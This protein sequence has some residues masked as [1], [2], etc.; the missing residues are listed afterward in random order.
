MSVAEAPS[1]SIERACDVL[2]KAQRVLLTSHRRPD[3]D[4]TGSMAGR[5]VEARAWRVIAWA[6]PSTEVGSPTTSSPG[7]HS[8][9]SFSTCENCDTAGSGCAVPS[10]GSPTATP[11]LVGLY[12]TAA[13]WFTAST[14]RQPCGDPCAHALEQLCRDCPPLSS[15]IRR[16]IAAR[17]GGRIRRFSVALFW[18]PFRLIRESTLTCPACGRIGPIG[19]FEGRNGGGARTLPRGAA[20]R[21]NMSNEISRRK[22][23]GAAAT[24]ALGSAVLVGCV[25]AIQFFA[26]K[27]RSA[28]SSDSFS[29]SRSVRLE[30]MMI[31]RFSPRNGGAAAGAPPMPKQ[32]KAEARYRDHPNG[33]QRCG[34]CANFVPPNDCR[35]IEGPVMENGW[36]RN[37]R[38]K[39]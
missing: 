4:G 10:S 1:A 24:T 3:G 5:S 19:C 36:C 29:G 25:A 20:G 16:C 9:T 38:A 18:N 15:R 33:P 35:V 7:F 22:L 26:G 27:N 2:R 28:T 30:R 17:R 32:T 37:F 11:M 12:I 31:V 8:A 21:K 13:Y 6:L 39:A 34:L 14:V 23:I